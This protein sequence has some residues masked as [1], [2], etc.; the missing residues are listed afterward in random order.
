MKAPGPSRFSLCPRDGGRGE[1]NGPILKRHRVPG[2]GRRDW[3]EGEGEGVRQGMELADLQ[4]VM[5]SRN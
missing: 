5:K 2:G 1:T 3:L 4:V